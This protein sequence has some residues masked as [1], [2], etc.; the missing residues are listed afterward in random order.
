MV[1]YAIVCLTMCD[2]RTRNQRVRPSDPGADSSSARAIVENT[3]DVST[4]TRVNALLSHISLTLTSSAPFHPERRTTMAH[5]ERTQ[6]QHNDADDVEAIPAEDMSLALIEEQADRSIRRV[7]YDGRWFFS[8]I[9]VIG[10]LTDSTFPNRYWSDLKRKL[11]AEGATQPYDFFVRL[12]LQSPDGKQRL[13]DAAD[14]ETLLRIVQSVPSPKNAAFHVGKYS[15]IPDVQ[16]ERV[17][18]WFQVRLDAAERR[19]RGQ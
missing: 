2:G 16:W 19:Q 4:L 15:D 8:V 5:D 11:I 12:K 18:A 1:E 10:V 6:P 13:T 7:W 17:E 14:T 3:T 9:D